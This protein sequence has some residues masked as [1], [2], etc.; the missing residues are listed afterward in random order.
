M[1]FSK[2]LVNRFGPKLAIFPFLFGNLGQ[3]NVI[4]DI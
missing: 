3:E 2:G 1:I 4:Y